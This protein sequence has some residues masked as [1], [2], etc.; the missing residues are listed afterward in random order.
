VT[1]RAVLMAASAGA[2]A[3]LMVTVDAAKVGSARLAATRHLPGAGLAIALAG[4][5]GPALW[6]ADSKT[7]PPCT[8]NK[9]R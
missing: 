8:P 3:D 7:T 4:A 1:G 5:L 2:S 9:G 6:A